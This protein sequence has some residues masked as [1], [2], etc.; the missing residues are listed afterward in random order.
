VSA[1][2]GGDGDGDGDTGDGDG[3]TGDGDG[4]TGN[5]EVPDKDC[6]IN[7]DCGLSY[8]CVSCGL[9]DGEGWC[10]Q[11]M[12]CSFDEDCGFGGKCG[13]NVETADYRCLPAAY[14]P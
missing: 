4:D 8:E 2:A 6:V 14:C 11:S 3:D 1:C 13:Y 5:P 12:G 7:N 10:L 9:T